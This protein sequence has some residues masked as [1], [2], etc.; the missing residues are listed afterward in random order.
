MYVIDATSVTRIGDPTINYA[1]VEE[2]IV[3]AG[4]A[5]DVAMV[6]MPACGTVV[7]GRRG[8]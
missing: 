6:N 7:A 8:V 1:N 4:S 3:S 2:L 5:N